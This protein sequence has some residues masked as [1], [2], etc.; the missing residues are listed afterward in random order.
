MHTRQQC[1]TC[2]RNPCQFVYV[3]VAA[4]RLNEKRELDSRD[5]YQYKYISIYSFETMNHLF[6]ICTQE[7]RYM[8]EA[9]IRALNVL[10]VLKDTQIEYY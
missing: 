5:I 1:S 9:I 10:L 8:N 6:G 7:S 3:H 2:V 4:G